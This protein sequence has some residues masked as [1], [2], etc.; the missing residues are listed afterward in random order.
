LSERVLGRI[1]QF[2]FDQPGVSRGAGDRQAALGLRSAPLTQ[3]L[4]CAARGARRAEG[5][6]DKHSVG[7]AS[8][9]PDR[10]SE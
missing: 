2:R 4:A 1:R 7:G 5:R 6:V 9:V 3:R 8:S 10:P